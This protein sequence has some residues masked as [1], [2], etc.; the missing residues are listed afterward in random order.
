VA[1]TPNVEMNVTDRFAFAYLDMLATHLPVVFVANVFQIRNVV[2]IKP[3][4][5]TNVL[6]RVTNRVA[7][8]LFAS[9][10][11]MWLFVDVHV[12]LL[13]IHSGYVNAAHHAKGLVNPKV[14]KK[15][16]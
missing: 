7:S 12:A 8:R 9:H 5:I 16:P 3:V 6:T 15:N 4:K 13:V 1:Q 2:K 10:K 11:I 14:L